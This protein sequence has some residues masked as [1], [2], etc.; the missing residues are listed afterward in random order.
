MDYNFSAGPAMLPQSIVKEAKKEM[1]DYRGTGR[2]IIEVT[3]RSDVYNE[4]LAD[5]EDLLRKLMN[6]PRQYTVLFMQSGASQ[7]FAMV[8]VNLMGKN[9]QA[10]YINTGIWSKKAIAQARLFGKVHVAASSEDDDFSYIPKRYSFSPTADYV[11]I[12]MNNTVEGTRF[13]HLPD[14]GD[15]PL[16]AD[17]SSNILS[18]EVDV[19][20]FALIYTGPPKN[21]GPIGMAIAIIRTD[22]MDGRHANV[23]QVLQY[24]MYAKDKPLSNTLSCVNLYLLNL[25]LKW[26]DKLGGPQKMAEINRKKAEIL[27]GF[28]AESKIFASRVNE[29]DR[30]MMNI[31]IAI[32]DDELRKRFIAA[33][34][35][36]RLFLGQG[37]KAAGRVMVS[38]YNTM[39]VK[40]V[41]RLVQ[42]MKNF[43]INNVKGC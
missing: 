36:E 17:M 42:F 25:V 41:K 21:L 10:D 37:H 12:T 34:T 26:L 14:T 9:R 1:F 3:Y 8:P 5:T 24:S 31:P 18:G 27:Y 4:I 38:I 43:E 13:T 15:I 6:I 16:V 23:P 20:K 19:S 40:G 30:S 29:P 28:L 11:H 39:P 32:E 7:Q 35:G 22:L 2:A 33:A